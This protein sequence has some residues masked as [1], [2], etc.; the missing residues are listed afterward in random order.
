MKTKILLCFLCLQTDP[1]KKKGKWKEKIDRQK[2]TNK[3]YQ[4][5]SD[6]DESSKT[7]D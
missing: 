5:T 1:K 4:Q 2:S 6:T 7:D 3:G